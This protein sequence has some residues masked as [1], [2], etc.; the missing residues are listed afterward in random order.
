MLRLAPPADKRFVAVQ[1]LGRHDERNVSL[2]CANE[3]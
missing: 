2:G 3:L 1:A